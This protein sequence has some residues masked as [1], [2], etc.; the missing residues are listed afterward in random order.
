[1]AVAALTM[2]VP[3]LG[4]KDFFLARQPILNIE[5]ELIG[6][7]LLFRSTAVNRAT[8]TD[9]VAA[10]AAVIE[11]AAELGLHNVIGS[12]TAFLNVDA[13]ML[14]SE[15]IFVLPKEQ[16]ILEILETVELTPSLMRRIETLV[17]AGYVFAIDDLVEESARTEQ[18]M[19]LAR[20]VKV[21]VL[22]MQVE[23]LAALSASLKLKGKKL[24]AEKVETSE[25][26]KLC[27]D[28]GFDY[29][30]G[31]YFARP[32]VLQGKK[33]SASCVVIMQILALIIKGANNY[34]IV[35]FIKQDVALSLM[36]L[37][38]V[39]TP[40]CGFR[41]H[42]ASLG[43]AL[44]VLGDRQL[45]RWLQILLYANPNSNRNAA[46]SPLMILAAT[47]GKMCELLSQKIQ[48]RRPNKSDTA[49]MVGVLSLTDAL[50]NL[51]IADVI[52]PLGVSIEIREAL[53]SR[54]GF[55][56][57][58][59][60]LVESVER[61]ELLSSAQLNEMLSNFQLSAGEFYNLQKEAFE[62]GDSISENMSADTP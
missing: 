20:I 37:R 41:R 55:Y 54:A 48:P 49:F 2:D 32:D 23:T 22:D 58:L 35:R 24:L 4:A 6:Y 10:T 29:Y 13:S 25:Q 5:Q 52:G 56:G 46:S 57:G 19:P 39:N 1:M 3:D 27:R 16:V 31:Y 42:I 62:W 12:L 26:F 36:L 61:P 18:L 50:F 17:E 21:D 44:L 45:K 59:L 47:R 7:E 30:Q 38:L 8:V 11:H 28:Y 9:D 43:Q 60:T 51:E 14:M 33:L 40:L 15:V 53:L 34:E